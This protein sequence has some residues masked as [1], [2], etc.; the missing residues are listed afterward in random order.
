MLALWNTDHFEPNFEYD[1]RKGPCEDVLGGE[2]VYVAQGAQGLFPH[3]PTVQSLG[4]QGYFGTP[5]LSSQE[6]VVGHLAIMDHKPLNMSIQEQ[7]L[8]QVFAA[9]AGAELERKYAQEAL[10]ESQGRYRALYDQAPLMYFTVDANLLVLS[11]NQFGAD[12][13]G[14]SI[15]DLVGQ[16]VLN[17]VH[18]E[19]HALFLQ[20]A[21][22]SLQS[23]NA[24]SQVEFRK[25]K[26]DG[27]VLW[28]KET[29]QQ[30]VD[31]HQGQTLLLSCEDVSDRKRAEEALVRSEK[32][33]R[34]TQKMEAVGTLAGGIAHDF[35]NILGAILGYSELA[36]T[37][38]GSN[39][40]LAGYLEEVLTAGHRAKEL[41][42][43][44]L[45]FSR[46]SDQERQAVD[47][48]S[49]VEEVLKLVRATVPTTIDIQ[50]HNA[51]ESAVVFADPTQIHQVLM[52]L[53][54]NS[55]HAMREK[56][57]TLRISLSNIKLAGGDLNGFPEVKPGSYV[58]L[59][60]EDTGQ[61]VPPNLLERIFE[62]FFTTKVAGE[63]TGLGLAVCP[64]NYRG[65]WGRNL[66]Q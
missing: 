59:T 1:F 12:L 56:G 52:N 25:I 16:P 57:G 22:K 40:Q 45:A 28:V 49:V 48:Y 27:Q 41:V 13:L 44:I 32:Q 64:W 43:Q 9:R 61:G 42:K 24:T 58:K 46:R 20:Q 66:C 8:V 21:E 15:S 53:C 30:R 18:S 17:V 31:P 5:L 14:Y 23:G 54:A 11:V 38:V 51:A 50:A 7:S 6:E 34:H 39:H 35:N 60:L 19:D 62:P 2:T 55:E 4:I 47:L 63:G 65:A 3:S 10:E 33:L 36:T 29:V 26:K 37:Q